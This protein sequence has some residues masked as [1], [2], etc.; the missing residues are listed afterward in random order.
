MRAKKSPSSN[1]IDIRLV[2]EY[3]D[4][5]SSFEVQDIVE[6]NSIK[7]AFNCSASIS[8]YVMYHSYVFEG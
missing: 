4:I 5:L 7:D 3:F 8:I 1:L 2:R 6:V